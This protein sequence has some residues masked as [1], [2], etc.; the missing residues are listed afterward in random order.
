MLV[1]IKSAPNTPEGKRAIELA[2]DAGADVC[3]LQNGVYFAC[4]ECLND[5]GGTS[6]LVGED[7][8]LRGLTDS[9]LCKKTKKIDYD[10]LVDLLSEDDRIIGAL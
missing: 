2:R 7:A 10:D 9:E 6:Y 8:R 3:L 1:I 5:F 4:G